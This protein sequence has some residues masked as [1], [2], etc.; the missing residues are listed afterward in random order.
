M[1]ELRPA[2]MSSFLVDDQ[3]VNRS[4]PD[5]FA[6]IAYLRRWSPTVILSDGDVVFQPRKGQRSGLWGGA[7]RH[8]ARHDVLMDNKLR[9]LAAM[10]KVLKNGL[11]TAFPRQGHCALDPQSLSTYPPVDLAVDRIGDLLHWNCSTLN[12][13][14]EAVALERESI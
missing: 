7:S 6:T 10:T 13:A 12:G 11:T 3:F 8:P 4:Y 5:A 2:L 14:A 9:I 1:N